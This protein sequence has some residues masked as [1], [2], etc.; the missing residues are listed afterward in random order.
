VIL[1]AV[2]LVALSTLLPLEARAATLQQIGGPN[3]ASRASP[4]ASEGERGF[5]FERPRGSIAI[6]SGLLFHRA[7]SDVFT[8][9]EE[10]FT[11]DRSDFRAVSIGVEGTMWFGDH[12][13]GTITVDG[14]RVTLNSESRDW[15][16]ED[17]SPIRQNT[18]LAFGPSV[19]VGARYFVL[20]RGENLG[21]LVW[22]PRRLNLF[23][24]GGAGVAPYR[25]EQW[26]DF[27][28]ETNATVFTSDVRSKGT[29]FTPHLTGGTSLRL[30]PR[31]ALLFEGRYQ[32]GEAE[33]QDQFSGFEPIDLAGLRTTMS[34]GYSF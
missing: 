26:G 8:F 20:G 29:V 1:S 9:A 12:L 27:V 25:F 10:R 18:R 4:P 7:G 19:A 31:V 17:G 14:S 21:R 16:E 22:I 34:L 28:N 3:S 24:G 5:L 13:E 11:V 30:T 2:V 32:W 33:L 6:R 15:L 23:V